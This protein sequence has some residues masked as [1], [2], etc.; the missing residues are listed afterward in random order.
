MSENK[1]NLRMEKIT[2]VFGPVTAVKDVTLCTW[3]GKVHALCGENGAGKS[4]LMKILA[5]VYRPDNGK[6]FID[7]KEMNFTHPGQALDAGISILYQELDLAEHLTVYE[8]IFLGREIK[9]LIPFVIDRKAMIEQTQKLCEQ[10]GFDIDPTDQISNLTTGQCQI[11]ELLKA[12]MRN[13]NIIVMDEPTSSL[14]EEEAK[15]LFEIIRELRQKNLTIIYISHRMQEVKLLADQITVLRDGEVVGSG[16]SS[17]MDIQ[18]VIRLMVGRELKEYYPKRKPQ[19]GSV[20]FEAVQ[21]A[22]GEGI[23]G[24]SFNVRRG[25]IVGIA[26]LVGSGRTEVARAIFGIKPLTAGLIKINGK[27]VK[28]KKPSDAVR[29]RMAFLTEDRKR[30]GLCLNLPCSWNMTLPNY[31]TIGMKTLLNLRRE[32]QLCQTYGEKVSVRWMQAGS[33]VNSLSGGNQQKLLIGRWLMAD[34]DFIIFDEP[35]RGIDI[36]AKKEV[37]ILLN[38]LAGQGKAI[39]IISSELPELFGI[40]DRILVMRRGRIAGDL[41]T[42]KTTPEKIMH[43]AAVE[44]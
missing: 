7:E 39:L 41:E 33:P 28:I 19:I 20:F 29:N 43:L 40:C 6:M 5:G 30:T 13:A 18:K 14:S 15:R 27:T 34:S 2:K 22:S 44:Q 26:G 1:G 23:S 38:E 8:N 16:P 32:E 11:V 3:P 42:S 10:Y 24:I 9:S 25:E 36:G 31:R 4:T 12:L 17:E 35:T 37:F 21:L